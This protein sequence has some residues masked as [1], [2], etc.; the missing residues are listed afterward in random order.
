MITFVLDIPFPAKKLEELKENLLYA[1]KKII[2][3]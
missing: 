1:M 3:V 2:V